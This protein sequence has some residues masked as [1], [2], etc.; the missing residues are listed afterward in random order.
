MDAVVSAMQVVVPIYLMIVIGYIAKRFGVFSRDT[1]KEMNRSVFRIFLPMLLFEN[2]VQAT[3]SVSDAG[4]LLYAAAC[5]FVIYLAVCIIV[6]QVVKDRSRAATVA[7]GMYR[8][9]FALLGI[10]L[11][12]TMYGS[13]QTEVTGMLVAVIVPLYNVLAVI[14]FEIAKGEKKPNVG[15][16]LLGV[17][18]NPLILGTGLGLLVHLS[19]LQIPTMINSAIVSL[20]QIATPL[21]LVVM[22]GNFEFRQTL[23]NRKPL[24]AVASVRLVLIPILFTILAVLVGYRGKALYAL[25]LMYATPTAVASYAMA[26]V[27][28]GD[29]D[30]AGEIVLI[31]TVLSLLTVGIGVFLLNAFALIQ[32]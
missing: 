30:L 6:F 5:A 12:E 32:I 13:G 10:A 28:G 23:R 4:L 3:L 29:E 2:M 21:A 14:L 8:S 22:G 7:Q 17:A 1:L 27:M 11:T 19:G 24:F 31:T 18:K 20:G 25:F 26:S 9:N 15:K 16:I